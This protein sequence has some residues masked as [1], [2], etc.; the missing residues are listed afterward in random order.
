MTVRRRLFAACFLIAI[1]GI[2][3]AEERTV[4][5]E[6]ARS[7]EYSG[8]TDE[9]GIETVRFTGGVSLV[10]TEGTTV[11]RISADEIV[12]DKTNE[13]YNFV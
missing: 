4:R 12:Y 8:K 11:S 2:A 10:V 9:T 3:G 6:T 1:L 13:S 5:I 7:T